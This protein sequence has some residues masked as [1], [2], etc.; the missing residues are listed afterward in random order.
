[1]SYTVDQKIGKYIYVY[2]KEKG[3]DKGAAKG[4][5]KL[6]NLLFFDNAKTP[7]NQCARPRGY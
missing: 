5:K 3:G 7:D 2:V 1:M 4:H 6:T